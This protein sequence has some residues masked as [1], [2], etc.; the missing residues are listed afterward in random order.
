MLL[1]QGS[2]LTP[3]GVMAIVTGHEE[4]RGAVYRHA[5]GR[6]YYLGLREDRRLWKEREFQFMG[7]IPFIRA[8]FRDA[9]KDGASASIPWPGIY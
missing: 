5:D 4:P 1:P 9:A 7:T 3:H 6:V 8:R 2:E